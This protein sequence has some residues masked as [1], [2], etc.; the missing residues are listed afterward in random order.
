MIIREL[1]SNMKSG[2]HSGKGHK[3][4]R[5]GKYEKALWH[6]QRA[7]EYDSRAGQCGSGLNP[8]TIECIARTHARLGNYK[9]ALIEA[10]KSYDL[11]KR[12]NPNTRIVAESKARIEAFINILKNGNTEEIKKILNILE[13]KEGHIPH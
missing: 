3:A 4:T 11:Y 8:V 12:L 7:V 6:Y 10:E 2:W 1:I 5:Q 9:E 13:R